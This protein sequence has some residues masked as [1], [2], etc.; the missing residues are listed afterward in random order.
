VRDLLLAGALA[1]DARVLLDEQGR[2]RVEGDPT[3]GALLVAAEKAELDPRALNEQQPRRHEIAFTS[4]RRRM[5]TLHETGHGLVAYSKGAV[6]VVL[7]DCATWLREGRDVPLEPSDRDAIVALERDMASV[8]LRVLAIA[9]KPMTSVDEAE[10][11]MTWLGLVAMMDPPRSEARQAVHTCWGAGITPVMITG[12]HPHTAKAI[13][14][15]LGLLDGRRRVVSGQ[16]L[17]R[18][19]DEEL[20]RD[21]ESI[22]VFARVSPT[23]KLR[24]VD[25]W[26]RRGDVVAVTGDG[27]NDAPALKKADV[28]IAMGISGTDVSKE[29]ASV[30]LLDDNF[31][32]IV[33]AV[34]EGRIV[35]SNIRKY[36][37]F[38]LSSNV[39][40]ILLMAGSAVAGLPLPLTAVQ[41]LYVN[42]ATDGLP[43]LALAVDPPD[44]DLMQR[45]PRDPRAGLFTRPL[46]MRLLAS[47]IWSAAVNLGLFAW[48]LR[49]GRPLNEAMALTFVSLVLIQFFNAY[50]YRS[51][52]TS[53]FHKP[54]ANRWLNAA[55]AWEVLLLAA[56]VYIPFF[57][58]FVGT[59]SFPWSDV[60][61]TAAVAFSIVPVLETVKWM[62]RRSAETAA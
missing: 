10:R 37:T 55:V 47:G 45:Q 62:Q 13:A 50:I 4:E 8:G 14:V 39:G 52:R 61:L 59:F 36:L 25:A 56:I 40:E 34:E 2:W 23:D 44:R 21:I 20:V 57:Q 11:A 19:T 9:R 51:E 60:A 22:G 41:I 15:E 18:M 7:P 27:V 1:S 42:L 38:L 33:A 31:A 49:N 24:V 12:D 54:F 46:V 28:G 32:T 43:A 26:Q 17:S 16:E 29:A 48:L 5:T 6:D 3:E 35:F 53:V 58:P 30:T